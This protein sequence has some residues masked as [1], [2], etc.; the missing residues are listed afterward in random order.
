MEF[1]L[2]QMIALP[3]PLLAG[4]EASEGFNPLQV[5]DWSLYLWTVVVFLV[6]FFFLSKFAWGPILKMVSDREDR[7]RGDLS[8]AEEARRE[9][10][11][12]RERHRREMEQASIQAKGLLDEAR[13]RAAALQGQ[14]EATA[15]QEAE[16]MIAKAKRQIEADKLAAMQQIRDQV[17]DLSIEISRRLASESNSLEDHLRMASELIPKVSQLS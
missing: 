2:S 5:G 15:R 14:L 4:G 16:A 12:I 9:A 17:V 8:S 3:L 1:I 7:I 11:E 10:E 6:L 13:E